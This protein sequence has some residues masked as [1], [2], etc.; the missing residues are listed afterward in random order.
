MD[1]WSKKYADEFSPSLKMP[2]QYMCEAEK[3]TSA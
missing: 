2:T 1:T 3:V